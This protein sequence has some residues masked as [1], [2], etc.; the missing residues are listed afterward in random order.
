MTYCDARLIHSI[1]SSQPYGQNTLLIVE[2]E[3]CIIIEKTDYKNYKKQRHTV[4]MT[5][6]SGLSCLTFSSCMQQVK[7][8]H[9]DLQ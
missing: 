5:I 3:K 9:T 4:L 2:A 6:V 7:A 1:I 8:M